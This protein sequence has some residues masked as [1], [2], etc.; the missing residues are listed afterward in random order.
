M[1]KI[2]FALTHLVDMFQI[3]KHLFEVSILKI[4]DTKIFEKIENHIEFSRN[5]EEN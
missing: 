3:L 1:L 5:S 2:Q 4:Q